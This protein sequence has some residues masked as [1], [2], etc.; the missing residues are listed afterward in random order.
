MIVLV[1]RYVIW[2]MGVID[3]L[4]IVIHRHLSGSTKI[5]ISD[6]GT[7]SLSGKWCLKKCGFRLG[8]E[9]SEPHDQEHLIDSCQ[10][11]RTTT[12][13]G[14]VRYSHHAYTYVHKYDWYTRRHSKYFLQYTAVRVNDNVR[15]Q[16]TTPHTAQ[17]MGRSDVFADFSSSNH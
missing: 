16:F 11:M 2:R 14:R 7:V 6:T 4:R 17:R 12:V 1:K 5:T 8:V 10:K 15:V 9:P 3:F 13:S